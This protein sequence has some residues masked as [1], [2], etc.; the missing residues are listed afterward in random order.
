MKEY[1]Q[2]EAI[3]LEQTCIQLRDEVERLSRE[4]GQ[5]KGDWHRKCDELDEQG[6]KLNRLRIAAK[7]VVEARHYHGDDGWDRLKNAI[8][9]LEGLV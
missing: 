4:L 3:L 2:T 7:A 5:V 8:A 6:G 9:E 1:S